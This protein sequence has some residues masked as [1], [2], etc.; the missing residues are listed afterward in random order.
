MHRLFRTPSAVAC[1]LLMALVQAPRPAA[2]HDTWFAARPGQQAGAW[3]LDLGTGNRFPRHEFT[4][5]A[6]SLRHQGCR[7]GLRMPVALRSRHGTAT[8]LELGLRVPGGARRGQSGAVTCWAELQPL[9]ITID[10]DRVQVY[11]DE[12]AAPAAVRAAWRDQRARGVPWQE[13]YR[14][15]A[16]IELLDRRLGGGDAPPAAP[17]PLA[18]DIVLDSGLEPPGAGDEIRFRVLRDGQPLPAQAIEARSALSPFGLWVRTDAEGRATVR[19]P[20]AG[21]WLLR[22]TDLRLSTTQA[23]AW[24]S[25]F[26]TLAFEVAARPR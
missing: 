15:H 10:A 6:A 7:Q 20:L 24:E 12:I 8:A 23:D 17:V 22:G 13:R 4:L 21:P 5:T 26:V 2:A 1:L 3:R 19:L 18:M 25:R 14:K 9:D 16:R 11:L